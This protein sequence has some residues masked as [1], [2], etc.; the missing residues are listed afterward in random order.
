MKSILVITSEFPP[1]PGGIGNHAFLLASK[2]AEKGYDITLIADQRDA[3]NEV[4]QRFDQSLSFKVLRVKLRKIRTLMYFQRLFKLFKHARRHDMIMATGKFSLWS[5]AMLRLFFRKE[6]LAI[7]HGT[8]VNFKDKFNRPL[9]DAAL[10]GFHKI[11]A[12]SGFTKSLVSHLNLKNINVIPNGIDFEFWNQPNEEQI[13]LKGNPKLITV[14]HISERK[15]QLNVIRA[16][17]EVKKLFPDV[18]YHCIGIPT[19]AEEFLEEAKILGVDHH[20][21]F[22]VTKYQEQL[23]KYVR[24]CD[25]AVM[26]SNVTKTGDVEGFG[27]AILE[28]NAS[29][30]PA[31]GAKDCGIEDAIDPQKSGILIKNT[32][33]VA[34]KEALESI[35][36][37][38]ETYQSG[39]KLW[40]KKHDWETI[41]TQYI[42]YIES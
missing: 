25:V 35:L 14:G 13:T 20:V 10:K 12:V 27:I 28:A 26:L 32:D 24:A 7:I 33:T 22:H 2:L 29:G 16:L 23:I 19:K 21:E 3:D 36:N 38:Y 11:V 6:T 9:V 8:E 15:G 4:E 37:N 18:H 31:I 1:Q 30:L 17:P 40:A 34:M 5:V 39:A 41:I 42:T